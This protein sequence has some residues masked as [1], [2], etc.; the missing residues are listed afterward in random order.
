[1]GSGGGGAAGSSSSKIM[2]LRFRD[3]A[4]CGRVDVDDA[5]GALYVWAVEADELADEYC[6]REEVDEMVGALLRVGLTFGLGC[7]G[8]LSSSF[9]P[10]FLNFQAREAPLSGASLAGAA[11]G[12][13]LDEVAPL[14]VFSI[15]R[16]G[17]DGGASVGEEADESG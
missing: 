5:A 11:A 17:G 15:S 13:F 7:S 12:C 16:F 1:M 3:L 10:K 14:R 8:F 6:G 2:D 4:L 9:L